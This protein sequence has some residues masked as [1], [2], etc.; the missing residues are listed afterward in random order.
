MKE[1]LPDT[2]RSVTHR[3]KIGA[4]KDTIKFFITVGFYDDGRPGEVYLQ[5]DEKGTTLSGFCICCGVLMSLCLQSGVP[6]S[7]LHEKLSFQ[8][9]EPMGMTDD[10][11][12]PF[13]RSVIDYAARWMQAEFG[14]EK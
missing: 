14:G 11:N 12:I 10:K 4:G 6:L 1:R 9:F 13:A 5:V 8:E 2:R 7:K 3:V